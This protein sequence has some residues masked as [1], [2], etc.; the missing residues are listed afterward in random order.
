MQ[1]AIY[2]SLTRTIYPEETLSY[3]FSFQPIPAEEE[4]YDGH[5][6]S[7]TVESGSEPFAVIE[8]PDGYRISHNTS[9]WFLHIPDSPFVFDAERVYE[10]AQVQ[11]HGLLVVQKARPEEH[12][13]Y[14]VH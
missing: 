14:W 1:V 2:R 7:W 10:L 13:H 12:E 3:S 6:R 8:I 9:G 4:T 5:L 11:S